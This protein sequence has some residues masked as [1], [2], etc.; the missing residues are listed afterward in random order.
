[1]AVISYKDLPQIRAVNKSKKIVFC[2]GVFDLFHAG[3]VLFLEDC[4]KY[5]DILV[6]TVGNDFMIKRNKGNSRPI[7]DEDNRLKIVSAL[8]PVDYCLLEKTVLSHPLAHIEFVLK[9]LRP[10]YYVINEDAFDIAYRKQLVS[11]YNTRLIVL[12]RKCPKKYDNISTTK[13]IEKI[14]RL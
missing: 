5:G 1:M 13:I 3:H 7:L 10:D 14:K 2:S 11:D 6:V 9:R 4:K 12:K 8:K